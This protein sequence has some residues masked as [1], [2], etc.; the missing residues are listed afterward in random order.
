MDGVLVFAGT[1]SF[2]VL[3][4]KSKMAKTAKTAKTGISMTTTWRLPLF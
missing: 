4:L 2:F 3:E 1:P